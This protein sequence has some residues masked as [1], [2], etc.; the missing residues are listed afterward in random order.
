MI[1]GGPFKSNKGV[2]LPNTKISLPALT[3]KD[4]K[5]AEFIF[6]Q[7]VD[8]I[9][10]S[11]VRFSQDL[12]DLQELMA[13]HTDQKIPIIALNFLLDSFFCFLPQCLHTLA[14]SC[15]FSAHSGHFFN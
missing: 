8:W 5:D 14:F 15:M 2:N 9:A 11:F 4:I 13:K 10:L 3:E 6:T 12:I 7:D 1:Q